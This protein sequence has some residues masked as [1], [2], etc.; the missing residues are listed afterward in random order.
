MKWAC[1]ESGSIRSTEWICPIL[2]NGLEYYGISLKIH[3]TKLNTPKKLKKSFAY[4]EWGQCVQK[5]SLCKMTTF[6]LPSVYLYVHMGDSW[7]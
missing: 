2:L 6:T 7:R 5:W 1:T 4:K 3:S